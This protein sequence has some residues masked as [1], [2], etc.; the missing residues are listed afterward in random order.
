M[1]VVN[2]GPQASAQNPNARATWSWGR[3]GQPTP[4]VQLD[5]EGDADFA[6]DV[7]INNLLVT[8]TALGPFGGGVTWT[9]GRIT[10]GD[11]DQPDTSGAW[12][13]VAGISFASPAAAV[14]DVLDAAVSFMFE[15]APA[16]GHFYDFAVVV[17]GSPVVFSSS[18][19]AAPSLE[20]DPSLYRSPETYRT[21]GWTW[22]LEVTA[23]MI[24]A[25]VV[26][27][28]MY[29]KG[30]AVTNST[31]FASTNYPFRWRVGNFGS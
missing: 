27:F 14:G 2:I 11:V 31:V 8:G 13:A 30:G 15:G 28:Q 5:T 9:R 16:A 24:S 26:T 17:G 4:G 29:G 6:G 21:S 3:Q 23:P 18:G 10:S 25:G 1:G 19:A 22:N 12:A 20:G 7:V